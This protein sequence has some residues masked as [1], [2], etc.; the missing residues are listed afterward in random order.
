MRLT[1]F[2]CAGVAVAAPAAAQ[3]NP[4]PLAPL[5]VGSVDQAVQPTEEAKPRPAL[6]PAPPPKVIPKTW[7]SIL[8]AIG[9][10]EW[11]AA[12]LGI[13]AMPGDPLKP[14]A[15]AEL[16]TAK[17]SPKVELAPIMTLLAEA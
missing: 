14:Y 10:G 15:K 3:E 7:P 4:D 12:R 11:E 6:P 8:L 5:D 16:Y 9:N 1:I 13:D 17:G 2:L